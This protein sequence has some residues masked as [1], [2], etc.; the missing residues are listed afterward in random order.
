MRSSDWLATRD[1]VRGAALLFLLAPAAWSASPRRWWPA[2]RAIGATLARLRDLQHPGWRDVVS[3]AVGS[4]A[5]PV[6][7]RD[8]RGRCLAHA[9]RGM[10]ETLREYRPEGWQPDLTLEGKECIDE[11]LARGRGVILWVHRFHPFVHFM[12]LHRAGLSVCRASGVAHG[13]FYRSRFGRRWLNP[14]QT[15]VEDRYCERILIRSGSL[16]H[17]RELQKRLDQ[18][19]IVAL[20]FDALE[21]TR[22]VEIPFLQGRLS[23]A[24][25]AASLAIET[26]A[27]LLPVFTVSDRPDHYRVVVEPPVDFEETVERRRA[28]EQTVAAHVSRLEP[29]VLAHPGQ[30]ADWWRVLPSPLVP[31]L[32]T[33]ALASRGARA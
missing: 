6:G 28:V 26:S 14:V 3:A 21:S 30:W 9:I 27:T 31:A 8:V 33:E 24:T 16:S 2:C 1:L 15:R 10:L 20:Y 23:V 29:Y 32:D 11:A 17:L 4:R 18:N 5:L 7:A 22:N 12:A 25:R 19:G 13:H